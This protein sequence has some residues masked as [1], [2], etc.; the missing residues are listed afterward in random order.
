MSSLTVIC[1][2]VGRHLKTN[3]HSIVMLYSVVLI[4]SQGNPVVPL[5]IILFMIMS[6]SRNM[7]SNVI[8]QWFPISAICSPE[9]AQWRRV[10]GR[11]L[12]TYYL[13]HYLSV[14]IRE[15]VPT[16]DYGQLPCLCLR[17]LNNLQSL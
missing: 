3:K 1:N 12:G 16:R 9:E 5:K 8:F 7:K 15:N 10:R 17:I 4:F 11:H 6:S 2:P 14:D 13:Q